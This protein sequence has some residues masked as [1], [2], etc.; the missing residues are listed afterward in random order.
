MPATIRTAIAFLPMQKSASLS[1]T[2]F[3]TEHGF[4]EVKNFLTYYARVYCYDDPTLHPWFLFKDD[5]FVERYNKVVD[6]A[7]WQAGSARLPVAAPCGHWPPKFRRKNLRTTSE[8]GGR[9]CLI[10]RICF[11]RNGGKA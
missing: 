9:L 6:D 5:K 2:P 8:V 4:D 10:V 1:P 3:P 7:R 11:E